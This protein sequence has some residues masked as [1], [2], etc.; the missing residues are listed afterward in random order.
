MYGRPSR[1][2]NRGSGQRQQPPPPQ[3]QFPASPYL[4]PNVPFFQPHLGFIPHQN[5]NFP[6]QN[7]NLPMQNTGFQFS[8]PS[9]PGLH[10]PQSPNPG[11]GLPKV[12][13]TGSQP[14][15]STKKAGVDLLKINH[16]VA[17]A[18]TNLL[19]AGESISSWKL[20]QSALSILQVDTLDSL[21]YRMQEIS[22]LHRI[23]VRE[24]KVT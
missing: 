7:L 22:D 23:I 11:V 4:N 14:E 16:A 20:L 24:G 8:P 9:N 3:M 1:F 10:F 17:T 13:K 18:H 2:G 12:T 6:M 19:E 15:S 5:V 21:G